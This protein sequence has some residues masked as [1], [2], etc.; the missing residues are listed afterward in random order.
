MVGE[1]VLR[2]QLVGGG[3]VG[4]LIAV[5]RGDFLQGLGLAVQQQRHVLELEAHVILGHVVRVL[6]LKALGGVQGAGGVARALHDEAPVIGVHALKGGNGH[7]GKR[8]G[9]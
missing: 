9:P 2:P 6:H 3:T 8:A 1:E 5:R 4:S 7:L